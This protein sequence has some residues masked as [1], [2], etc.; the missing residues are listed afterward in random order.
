MVIAIHFKLVFPNFIWQ[1]QV[2]FIAG[3]NILDNII[4]AQ[5]VIHSTREKRVGKD[6]MVNKIDLEKPYDRVRWDFIVTSLLAV[7]VSK[8]LRRVIMSGIS[9]STMQ[10]F[11][12]G[13]PTR[14]L[15]LLKELD[16]GV[17]YHHI[18]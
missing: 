13:I 4:I 2:E 1:K 12:N 18:C 7:S 14:S 17:L 6:W 11:W 16:K 10:I 15:S 9:S 5:E 3:R 8:F